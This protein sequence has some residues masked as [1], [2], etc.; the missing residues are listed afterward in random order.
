MSD[1]LINE[2]NDSPTITFEGLLHELPEEG[3]ILEFGVAEGG[4]LRHIGNTIRHNNPIYGFDSFQGLPE[5]WERHAGYNK[6]HFACEVPSGF[7]SNIHLV[8]GLFQETLA[9][10]LE[11]NTQPIIFVHIDCDIY[12]ST[13]FVLEALRGRLNN[14]VFAFDE[15][16]SYSG[17][18][19]NEYK[20][21]NEFIDENKI[22]YQ[23]LGRYSTEKA[24]L[25]ITG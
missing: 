22:L 23:V 15:L 13:K 18:E 3:M 2:I 20:A 7:A 8:I 9:K 14:T 1:L 19:V 21:L 4:S 11:E 24:A 12:S 6:G 17:W 16:L 5:A 10:F 25:K